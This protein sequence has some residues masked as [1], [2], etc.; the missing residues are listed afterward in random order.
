M[1][2]SG[3]R[4]RR[5]TTPTRAQF[6]TPGPD[7]IAGYRL[8]SRNAGSQRTQIRKSRFSWTITLRIVAQTPGDWF[9]VSILWK[10]CPRPFTRGPVVTK[11]EGR[12]SVA[13]SGWCAPI[14]AP[15]DAGL[16]HVVGSAHGRRSLRDGERQGH[17]ARRVSILGEHVPILREGMIELPA[18]RPATVARRD[19]LDRAGHRIADDAGDLG[20]C[21]GGVRPPPA[22]SAV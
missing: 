2:I 22:A 8:P 9:S 1:S 17:G 10:K 5:F 15:I 12:E 11:R 3:F 7:H 6:W 14:E 4:C 18:H 20:P 13:R 19:R 21:G 16:D